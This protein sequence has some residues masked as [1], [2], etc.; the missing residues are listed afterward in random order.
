M[1]FFTGVSRTPVPFFN[2]L[3]CGTVI[4][5]NI[6]P[7]RGKHLAPRNN[8][9]IYTCQW[10]MDFK[11]LSNQPFGTISVTAFPIF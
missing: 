11:E 10:F 1:S 5:F 3:E 9:D 7:G 2:A 6:P 8:N 4:G